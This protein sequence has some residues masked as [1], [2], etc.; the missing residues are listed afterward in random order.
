MAAQ[1]LS[2]TLQRAN[3]L[4]IARRAAGSAPMLSAPLA[5]AREQLRFV[6]AARLTTITPLPSVASAASPAVSSFASAL[7]SAPPPMCS[8]AVVAG[9][10]SGP[11]RPLPLP[12][13]A[14]PPLRHC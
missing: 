6:A 11:L 7:T 2:V 4:A 5:A 14:K 10:A 1:A 13:A 9:D 3:A 8:V 12:D